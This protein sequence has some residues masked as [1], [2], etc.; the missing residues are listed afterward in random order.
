LS[1]VQNATTVSSGGHPGCRHA[2]SAAITAASSG[3]LNRA[4][5]QSRT[6]A[7]AA[8][9]SGLRL[10]AGLIRK[11]SGMAWPGSFWPA[12]QDFSAV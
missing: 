10:S 2:T 6:C 3:S 11:P 9:C 5:V 1:S 8:T 7:S 12:C 4:R